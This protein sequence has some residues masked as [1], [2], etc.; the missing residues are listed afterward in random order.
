[1][2]LQERTRSAAWTSGLVAALVGLAAA[3]PG[4]AAALPAA[5][6]AKAHNCEIQSIQCGSTVTGTLTEHD[7]FLPDFVPDLGIETF[8]DF[9]LSVEGAAGTTLTID[10]TSDQLDTFLI[11]SDERDECVEEECILAMDDDG[12]G[13]TDSRIVHTLDFSGPFA[14]LAAGFDAAQ[15][16]DYTL[17][18]ACSAPGTLSLL[19]GRFEITVDWRRPNGQAGT[20]T[21]IPLTD[22]AGLFYFFSEDNLEMLIKMLDACSLNGHFWLFYAATTNVEFTV[23]VFDT[24][25]GRFHTYHNLQGTAALPIQDTRAF[26]CP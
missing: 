9:W 26:T 19:D 24:V 13:G 14:I 5:L 12:G 18:L 22:Q 3:L 6:G 21:A 20:G 25:V 17:S 7:C 15:L 16:G 2:K 8:F 1:M 4:G 23:S 10:L 11:L